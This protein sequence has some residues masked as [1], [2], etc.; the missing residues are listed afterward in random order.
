MFVDVNESATGTTA[1]PALKSYTLDELVALRAVMVDGVKL[2][3]AKQLEGSIEDVE[4][5]DE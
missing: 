2:G 3:E 1:V 5:I 4:V